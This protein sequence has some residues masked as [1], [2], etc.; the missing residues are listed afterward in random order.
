M[1]S[2]D[3]GRQPAETCD[4]APQLSSTEIAAMKRLE[5]A[6]RDF[7]GP[8]ASDIFVEFGITAKEFYRRLYGQ[9]GRR[10]DLQPRQGT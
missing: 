3:P 4:T 6:W 7:G 10:T 2:R 9:Y 5:A 8:S 1:T